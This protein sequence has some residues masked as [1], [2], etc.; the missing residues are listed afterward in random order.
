MSQIIADQK[1]V[2]FHSQTVNAWY[3]T[4]L[5]Y[6][7]SLLTVSSAA[8]GLIVS[9]LTTKDISS[10]LIIYSCIVTLVFF[11]AAII[12]ILFVFRRNK[13]YIYKVLTGDEGNDKVLK[14]LDLAVLIFFAS[15]V[16]LSGFVGITAAI[17]S[18]D[19]GNIVAK[20]PGEHAAMEH[21]LK[22][23]DDLRKSMDGAGPLRA[24]SRSNSSPQSQQ[25]A[26]TV[27]PPSNTQSENNQQ[28]SAERNTNS[29]Q[30][31]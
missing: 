5:E 22:R 11:I 15:G 31:P 18:F 7:K 21:A 26:E 1:D 28:N 10:K 27:P 13:H 12:C 20:Q 19:K 24:T 6:D 29:T 16:V 23:Q 30:R 14:Y 25:P 17:Q 2:E 3:A 8:A 4:S 9:F